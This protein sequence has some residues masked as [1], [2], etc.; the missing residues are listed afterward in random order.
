MHARIG[1]LGKLG[2]LAVEN[3]G[4]SSPNSR[5]LYSLKTHTRAEEGEHGNGGGTPRLTY[6]WFVHGFVIREEHVCLQ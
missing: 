4:T 5:F 6:R 2:R 1:L 3:L